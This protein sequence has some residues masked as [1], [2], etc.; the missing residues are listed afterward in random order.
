MLL[1][2]AMAMVACFFQISASFLFS[3]LIPSDILSPSPSCSL[4]CLS[5]H[6]VPSPSYPCSLFAGFPIILQMHA[7]IQGL[8]E[9]SGWYLCLAPEPSWVLCI[10]FHFI[11]VYCIS[12]FFIALNCALRNSNSLFNNLAET[13]SELTINFTEHLFVGLNF[14]L[15]WILLLAVHGFIALLDSFNLV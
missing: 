6:Y 2:P 15:L 14:V 1:I 10:L 5:W 11:L 12:S 8:W 13:L 4:F 3:S 9:D 7:N